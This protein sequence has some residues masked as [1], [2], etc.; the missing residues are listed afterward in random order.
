MRITHVNN[1]ILRSQ[2]RQVEPSLDL[3]KPGYPLM[4][5]STALLVGILRYQPGWVE[6]VSFMRH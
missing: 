6:N 5:A 4:A 1:P 2:T 3:E